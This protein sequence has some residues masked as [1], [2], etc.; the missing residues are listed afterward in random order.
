MKVQKNSG[1]HLKVKDVQVSLQSGNCDLDGHSG[2]AVCLVDIKHFFITYCS[3]TEP[4][5]LY[6][7]I[8]GIDAQKLFQAMDA[9]LNSLLESHTFAAI[10]WL[11]DPNAITTKWIYLLNKEQLPNGRVA[12]QYKARLIACGFS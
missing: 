11:V 9:E 4:Y 1:G 12:I 10:K 6:Q 7:P 3:S 8:K 2:G 5:I